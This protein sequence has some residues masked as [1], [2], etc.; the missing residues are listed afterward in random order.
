MFGSICGGGVVDSW[1]GLAAGNSQA[2][3]SEHFHSPL[4]G[5]T[6]PLWPCQPPGHYTYSGDV[7]GGY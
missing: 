6:H 2:A 4:P 5:M 3:A 1:A 7:P